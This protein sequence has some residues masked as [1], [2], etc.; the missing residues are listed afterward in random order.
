M[1]AWT[2]TVAW[3]YKEVRLNQDKLVAESLMI[4]E[5]GNY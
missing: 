1:R 5:H 2:N 3:R 4:V